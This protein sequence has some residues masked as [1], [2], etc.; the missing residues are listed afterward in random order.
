MLNSLAKHPRLWQIV[1]LY[2]LKPVEG[3]KMDLSI[4]FECPECRKVQPLKVADLSPGRSRVC[5][6]CGAATEL[7]DVGAAELERRLREFFRS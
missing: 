1:N 4:N 7:T 6:D 3:G 5:H 2:Q